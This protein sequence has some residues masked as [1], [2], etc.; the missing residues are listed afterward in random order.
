MT[1]AKTS[2]TGRDSGTGGN[3]V[4]KMRGVVEVGA[5]KIADDG[6]VDDVDVEVEMGRTIGTTFQET[7]FE[8]IVQV[9]L[10]RAPTLK[11]T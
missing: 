8:P 5:M 6:A 3:V 4:V 10:G 2:P 11:Q 1:P 7:H 9:G